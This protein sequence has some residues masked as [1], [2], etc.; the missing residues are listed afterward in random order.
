MSLLSCTYVYIYVA[1]LASKIPKTLNDLLF[2]AGFEK[3]SRNSEEKEI[4]E[5]LNRERAL[6]F[7]K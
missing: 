3:L 2:C 7:L 1:N 6:H 4:H 5:D